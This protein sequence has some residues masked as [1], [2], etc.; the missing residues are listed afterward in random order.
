MGKGTPDQ[1]AL[2][3]PLGADTAQLKTFTRHLK[4]SVA[5][6][7]GALHVV[8]SDTG[9]ESNRIFRRTAE[10]IDIGFTHLDALTVCSWLFIF[11]N[12]IQQQLT[13]FMNIN[14]GVIQTLITHF[15]V[16]RVAFKQITN[17]GAACFFRV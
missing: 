3:H 6:K 7:L 15:D 12:R 8:I 5:I 1:L 13:R 14:F 11:A 16:I 4:Q 2:I 17:L 9:T 10:F